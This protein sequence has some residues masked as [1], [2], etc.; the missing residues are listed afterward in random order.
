MIDK[1]LL[2]S[3]GPVLSW[4]QAWPE[5][6]DVTVWI[7]VAK[8]DIAWRRDDLYISPGAPD[9]RYKYDRF[10]RW[11]MTANKPLEMPHVTLR[12]WTLS[13]TDGRHRFA[14][15]RDNGIKSMPITTDPQIAA[16]TRRVLGSMLSVCV[17]PP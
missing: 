1:E 12:Y 3:R 7:D 6:G 14:W 11:L 10:G 2:A 17:L 8:A 16:R 13:F 5:A 4:V 15:L 9:H